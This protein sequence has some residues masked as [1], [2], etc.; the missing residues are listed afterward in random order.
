[1]CVVCESAF[2]RHQPARHR[3]GHASGQSTK[4]RTV[5]RC[6]RLGLL[7]RR[8]ATDC[9][10]R[11][12]GAPRSNAYGILGSRRQKIVG[13]R[14]LRL[15][16]HSRGIGARDISGAGS[17]A[18]GICDTWRRCFNNCHDVDGQA[19]DAMG[20]RFDLSICDHDLASSSGDLRICRADGRRTAGR[21]GRR[22]LPGGCVGPA[23]V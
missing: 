1:M 6:H 21:Q 15:Q 16:R 17:A 7:C 19:G 2:R 23:S 10:W 11:N 18:L 4:R 8:R 13:R 14:S 3:A 20:R 12:R 5:S 9:D 22:G